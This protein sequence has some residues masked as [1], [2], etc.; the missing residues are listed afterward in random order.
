MQ[1]FGL[2]CNPKRA[3]RMLCN[4]HITSQARETTQILFT[5]LWLWGAKVDEF[6][7]C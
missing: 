2:D 6:V 7:D 4:T 1:L 3:A 5:V